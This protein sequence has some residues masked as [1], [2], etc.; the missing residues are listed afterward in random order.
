MNRREFINPNLPI[1]VFDSGLGGLTVVREIL[2]QLPHENIL[3]FGDLARLPYGIKS[4]RQITDFSRENTDFLIEC[5]VKAVVVAC[6]SSA[7]AAGNELRKSYDIPI[8]DVIRPAAREAVR[9]S[10]KK[11]IGVIAT[12]ATIASGAYEK[13]LKG[14]EP[15]A[16][17]FTQ[18]CPLFVPLVEEGILSG[19]I[20]DSVIGQ[21]IK[22]MTQKKIDTLILGCTHY[23][24][25]KAAIQ[26]YVGPKIG[27][28]DSA[29]PTVS[30]LCTLLESQ[31]L[32]SDSERKGDLHIFVSDLPQTFLKIGE[33]FLGK[34]LA[35][36]KLVRLTEK[37]TIHRKW[38]AGVT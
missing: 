7:S 13:T 18:A 6:N 26:R 10:G 9:I 11:R 38:A 15:K 3:Y 33:R 16:Q 25:L 24:L 30:D 5:G 4:K 2:K 17:V 32:L 27:L 20:A 19:Q 37:T 22:P 8:L 31:N 35:N 12:S 28:V 34:K 14:F 1:G 36:V 23:P 29:N 21:Y